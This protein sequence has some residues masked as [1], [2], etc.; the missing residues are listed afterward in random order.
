MSNLYNKFTD[1]SFFEDNY[2]NHIT[3]STNR[4]I[5]FINSCSKVG[6]STLIDKII[7]NNDK[8]TFINKVMK[9]KNKI[10]TYHDN[11]ITRFY[12]DVELIE[13]K[14][15]YIYIN[16][17]ISFQDD[18]ERL[19]INMT[20]EM[21]ELM[22]DIENTSKIHKICV[23]FD[24]SYVSLRLSLY[25]YNII[26]RVFPRKDILLINNKTELFNDFYS[27]E[28]NEDKKTMKNKGIN[29]LNTSCYLDIGISKLMKFLGIQDKIMYFFYMNKVIQNKDISRLS[30]QYF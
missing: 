18:N 27:N 1:N 5:L 3:N 26:S 14:T 2:V 30:V 19:T 21:K 8:K 25:F 24:D 7:Y 6:V 10:S 12:K 16:R 29:I 13:Y 17:R 15:G 4:K 9:R 28:I 20:Q 23:V 11:I 22:H